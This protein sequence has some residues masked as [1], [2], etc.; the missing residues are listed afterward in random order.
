MS[1]AVDRTLLD[2]A[3]LTAGRDLE[4]AVAQAIATK[5]T[6]LARLR[7]YAAQHRSRN[8]T[9]RLRA[10]IEAPTPPRFTRSE[11]EE[12]LLSLIRT[13][14]SFPTRSPTTRSIR[15]ELD[16]FWPEAL[17]A[18]EYDSFEFHGDEASFEHD[19]LRDARLAAEHGIQVL[20]VT[21]KQ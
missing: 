3:A 6:S 9:G 20:R 13:S 4:R 7:T 14:E 15:Y 5:R 2:L 19:R 1:R 10:L 17:L 21:R 16:V 18:V 12:R 8:G 11:A